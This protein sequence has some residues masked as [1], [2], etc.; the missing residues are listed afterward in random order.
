LCTPDEFVVV[1][2]STSQILC[3]EQVVPACL[4]WTEALKPLSVA[5]RS[6]LSSAVVTYIADFGCHHDLQA[7][8]LCFITY[9]WFVD[10]QTLLQE[11]QPIVGEP[12]QEQE[13]KK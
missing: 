3:A 11:L 8:M 10:R 2:L 5:W 6:N 9:A 1:S 12:I 7:T 13:T 4:V